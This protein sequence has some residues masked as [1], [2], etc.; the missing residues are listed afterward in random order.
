MST[1]W[2]KGFFISYKEG[3]NHLLLKCDLQQRAAGGWLHRLVQQVAALPCKRKPAAPDVGAGEPWS[4]CVRVCLGR[5]LGIRVSVT[6]L[7]VPPQS[8]AWVRSVFPGSE[9]GRALGF[10]SRGFS[11]TLELGSGWGAAHAPGPGCAAHR[12]SHSTPTGRQRVEE[13]RGGIKLLC[14]SLR[15]DLWRVQPAKEDLGSQEGAEVGGLTRSSWFLPRCS[16]G[17]ALCSTEGGRK[18]GVGWGCK[19]LCMHSSIKHKHIYAAVYNLFTQ[20]YWGIFIFYYTIK[21]E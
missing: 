5:R 11:I 10:G 18:H 6:T 13:M 3:E 4:H 16:R 12:A 7:S 14:L 2:I 17:R 1:H 19:D 8:G 20:F 15:M 9:L 21:Q